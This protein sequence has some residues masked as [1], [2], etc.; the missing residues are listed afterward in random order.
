MIKIRYNGGE[1]PKI[2]SDFV[3]VRCSSGIIV[4]YDEGVASLGES[5]GVKCCSMA[6]GLSF[7][8]SDVIFFDYKYAQREIPNWLGIRYGDFMVPEFGLVYSSTVE[9]VNK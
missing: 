6:T 3:I 5:N 7:Q 1:L 8:R 9:G 2:E 4:S